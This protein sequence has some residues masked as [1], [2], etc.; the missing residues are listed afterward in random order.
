MPTCLSNCN[1]KTFVDFPNPLISLGREQD[2]YI[3]I[4]YFIFLQ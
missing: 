2:H 1:V 3:S 4:L